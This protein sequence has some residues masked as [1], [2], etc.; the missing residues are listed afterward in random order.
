MASRIP[1]FSIT[2]PA[3]TLTTAPATFSLAFAP[4]RV[5]AIEVDIPPGPAGNVGFQ[6]QAGGRQYI[7]DNPGA[8]FILDD[9]HK[10]WP[11]DNANQQG[12]FKLVAYN[13]D[14]WDHLITVSFFVSEWPDSSSAPTS[15]FVS[16]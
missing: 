2:V 3:G 15:Q 9:V 8:F 5:D 13:T 7:P 1:A 16:V 11:I 10:H 12:S 6:I 14:I 4:G